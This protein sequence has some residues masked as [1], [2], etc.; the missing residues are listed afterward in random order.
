MGELK[1]AELTR[2]QFLLGGA[3]GAAVVWA[4]PKL[5]WWAPAG[6][7]T[8]T[9]ATDT[10]GDVTAALGGLPFGDN[11]DHELPGGLLRN[12]NVHQG[13]SLVGT[14]LFGAASPGN[15]ALDQADFLADH[16]HAVALSSAFGPGR[17]ETVQAFA[18]QALQRYTLSF[19][20]AGSHRVAD[21][22]PA[23]LVASL[24]GCAAALRVT[25]G[26]G[27]GFRTF[28]LQVRP[29]ASTTSTIVFA[30]DDAP[31]HAGL[32][33]DNVALAAG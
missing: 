11:F 9:P 12:W 28:Q 16:G 27:D 5:G 8:L 29:T 7:Q 24:P 13:I 14:S 20:V 4:T 23:T 17:I 2:R 25:M 10:A 19:D 26:S 22:W 33:L 31:G 21:P 32:I 30:S 1:P 6:A 3:A 15:G 18:F